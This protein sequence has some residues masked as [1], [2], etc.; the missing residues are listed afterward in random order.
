MKMRTERMFRYLFVKKFRLHMQRFLQEA[1]LDVSSS[2]ETLAGDDYGSW[3]LLEF[4]KF[5]KTKYYP[6]ED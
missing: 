1:N 2:M 3:L 6:T 4:P 5:K